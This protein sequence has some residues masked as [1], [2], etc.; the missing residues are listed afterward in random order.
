MSDSLRLRAIAVS[1]IA[2][3]LAVG[4]SAQSG[5]PSVKADGQLHTE[6][7]LIGR[8]AS[9]AFA[10]DL[11]AAD[12]AYKSLFAPAGQLTGR[13]KVGQLETNG[14]LRFGSIS[15]PVGL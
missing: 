9:I 5:K 11:R 4:T 14:G 3:A 13:A 8:T 7:S 6:L 15:E 1:A 2:L 12:A 10:P